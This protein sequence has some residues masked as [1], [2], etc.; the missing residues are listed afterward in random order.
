MS[1]CNYEQNQALYSARPTKFVTCDFSIK[2]QHQS[3]SLPRPLRLCLFAALS[4]H[5]L[6]QVPGAAAVLEEEEGEEEGECFAAAAII[7]IAASFTETDKESGDANISPAM[8]AGVLVVN[9]R[10]VL[11][12]RPGESICAI[13]EQLLRSPGR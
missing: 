2:F 1:R 7:M 11:K 6:P 10:C 4:N 13:V 8:S 12:G 5:I 3:F 9:D